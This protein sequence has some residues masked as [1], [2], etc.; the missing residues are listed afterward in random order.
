MVDVVTTHDPRYGSPEW[1]RIRRWVIDRDNNRCQM[2]GPN[3]NGWATTAD[4]I[5][6]PLDGGAFL[7]PVNLR[8]A[9]KPCNSRGGAL[10]AQA[11][12]RRRVVDYSTG[13]AG[14]LTRF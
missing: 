14:Y 3:C 13:V 2:A 10:R 12:G 9:C 11:G 8:A 4:H 6:S 5:V 7:D 1:K